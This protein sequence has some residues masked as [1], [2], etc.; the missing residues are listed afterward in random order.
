M[1]IGEQIY[2]SGAAPNAQAGAN[3]GADA[4]AAGEKKED[5]VDAEFTEKK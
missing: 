3:P 4:N 2:K 1:K 5:V